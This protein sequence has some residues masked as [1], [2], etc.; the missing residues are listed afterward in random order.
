MVARS[1]V[2]RLTRPMVA[3]ST[4]RTMMAMNLAVMDRA[5]V[6]LNIVGLL[7]LFDIDQV[8]VY[9]DTTDIATVHLTTMD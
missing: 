5:A 4:A 2:D 9:R 6:D 1:T 8:A 7:D 3:R